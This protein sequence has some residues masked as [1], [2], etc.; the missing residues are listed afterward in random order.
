MEGR[1]SLE[2]ELL[3]SRGL[4]QIIGKQGYFYMG[5]VL[6]KYDGDSIRY[7]DHKTVAEIDI[8]SKPFYSYKMADRAN[9]F[10]RSACTSHE[11]KVGKD[12][13]SGKEAWF[14]YTVS[15]DARPQ[16]DYVTG[17]Y[18]IGWWVS[19]NVVTEVQGKKKRWGKYRPYRT[20][21]F[22]DADLTIV[23]TG[24]LPKRYNYIQ[25]YETKSLTK[26]S[27]TGERYIP[28]YLPPS[29]SSS[30]VFH[31]V[32]WDTRGYDENDSRNPRLVF[33]CP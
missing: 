24:I 21:C 31:H 27:S 29:G 26:T 32:E 3:N 5:D 20:E 15:T 16:R 17:T 7:F 23:S 18:T 33:S 10:K 2:I 11:C 28:G 4:F 19:G 9:S 30:V 22:I 1:D 12:A 13:G 25:R 8:S 6:A 14:C